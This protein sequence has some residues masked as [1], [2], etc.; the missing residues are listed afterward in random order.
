MHLHPYQIVNTLLCSSVVYRSSTTENH[1][2]CIVVVNINII[3]ARLKSQMLIQIRLEYISDYITRHRKSVI[4]PMIDAI[5]DKTLEYSNSGG[6]A[7][8]GFTWNLHFNWR[9]V[10]PREKKR[11][12]SEAEAV[13]FV[14]LLCLF[15]CPFLSP[16]PVL[17][18][19]ENFV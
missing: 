13:Q 7:V 5:N 12:S 11:R 1:E 10:P 17:F 2:R 4:C 6:I 19:V 18:C 3:A 9:S 8:G 16:V 14:F 15:F